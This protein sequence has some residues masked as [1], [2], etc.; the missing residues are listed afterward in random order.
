MI[1]PGQIGTQGSLFSGE[2]GKP[3]STPRSRASGGREPHPPQHQGRAFASLT[4]GS[5]AAAV[6]FSRHD[7]FRRNRPSIWVGDAWRRREHT[8]PVGGRERCR[9]EHEYGCRG[10][11][12]RGLRSGGRQ[13]GRRLSM[14]PSARCADRVVTHQAGKAHHAL[15]RERR[16]RRSRR[17]G[18]C[19]F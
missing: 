10:A 1:E 16:F 11:S 6:V 9:R 15:L 8:A 19:F 14:R 12:S 4:I 7:P 18:I 2:I 13:T 3:P 5:G 17:L